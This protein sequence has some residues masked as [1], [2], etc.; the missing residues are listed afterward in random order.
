MIYSFIHPLSGKTSYLMGTMHSQDARAF[1]YFETA[2]NLMAACEIYAPEM[3][4]LE[5]DP[6]RLK[7][8]FTLPADLHLDRVWRA[9]KYE[10]YREIC[11]KCFGLDLAKL[12]DSAPIYIQGMMMA[13]CL[14]K[15]NPLTLDQALLFYARDCELS[16]QGVES[17]EEQYFI[18]QQLDAKE[19]IRQ[20]AVALSRPDRFRQQAGRLCEL[21]AQNDIQALYKI[22]KRSLG[23]FR[24]ILLYDRNIVMAQRIFE[25]SEHHKVFAA[26]GAAH[27]PGERGV[28]RLLKQRGCKLLP[29]RLQ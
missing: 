16:L 18:A 23:A 27:L 20:L 3:N 7:A 12:T 22:G 8:A 6:H 21:Y 26:V 19:Q 2:Q 29:I 11:Q 10:R 25:T 17:P 1:R 13:S 24:K 9:K 15:E 5:V 28:M 4:L 14:G